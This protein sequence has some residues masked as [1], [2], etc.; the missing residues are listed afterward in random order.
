MSNI[1]AID[2][3]VAIFQI[4]CH[5]ACFALFDIFPAPDFPA[6]SYVSMLRRYYFRFRF[7]QTT[8]S[9]MFD[10]YLPAFFRL[11]CHAAFAPRP[12]F[13]FISAIFRYGY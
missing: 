11:P 10:L 4:L 6:P 12:L 9:L 5:A 7:R 8:S 3:H 13:F 1:A 2:I